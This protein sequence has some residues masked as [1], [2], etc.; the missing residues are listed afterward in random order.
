MEPTVHWNMSLCNLIPAGT[1][2]IGTSS[3]GVSS[4]LPLK[5]VTLFVIQLK[6]RMNCGPTSPSIFLPLQY[7]P[8][9]NTLVVYIPPRQ[10][11]TV[12]NSLPHFNGINNTLKQFC[13]QFKASGN[14]SCV[15]F[16]ALRHLIT[17]PNLHRL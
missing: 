12:A 2:F 6:R 16:P 7:E 14:S 13:Q 4:I 17:Y 1:P 3:A 10:E 9:T 5:T 15:I 8:G 11:Q